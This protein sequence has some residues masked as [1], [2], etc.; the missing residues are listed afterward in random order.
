MQDS[1]AGCGPASLSNALAAVGIRRSVTECESLCGT[2]A[3]VGTPPPRMVKALKSL[4]I[5]GIDAHVIREKKGDVAMLR[6]EYSLRHGRPVLLVVDDGGH[7]VAAVGLLGGRYLV[8]DP[9]DT[10][11]VV[12]YEPDEIAARWS[13]GAAYYG[14]AL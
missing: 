9:A 2:N 12:S 5:V 8:A 13:D 3:T 4:G 7:W 11:L 10:E 14:V 1:Q 6:L